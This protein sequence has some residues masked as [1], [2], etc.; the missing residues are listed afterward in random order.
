MK[1]LIAII[2][3]IGIFNSS[4]YLCSEAVNLIEAE[5]T[6]LGYSL[7]E[8][9]KN[10]PWLKRKEDLARVGIYPP[11]TISKFQNYLL[12]HRKGFPTIGDGLDAKKN[13]FYSSKEWTDF[14]FA[15]DSRGPSILLRSKRYE[16]VM[17]YSAQVLRKLLSHAK[18]KHTGFLYYT[19]EGLSFEELFDLEIPPSLADVKESLIKSRNDKKIYRNKLIQSI[20]ADLLIKETRDFQE[21]FHLLE[22][23]NLSCLDSKV[24]QRI[25]ELFPVYELTNTSNDSL[26]DAFERMTKFFKQVSKLTE[27]LVERVDSSSNEELLSIFRILISLKEKVDRSILWF[28]QIAR[29]TEDSIRGILEEME[30]LHRELQHCAEEA[31][32]QWRVL[33]SIEEK[34]KNVVSREPLPLITSKYSSNILKEYPDFWRVKLSSPPDKLSKASD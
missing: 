29:K 22:C 20:V 15:I 7:E 9:N 17:E 16:R 26:S 19:S 5:T 27:V 1:K 10:F 24:L 14:K 4:S 28:E 23:V 6:Q 12:F 18:S 33:K 2:L 31:K 8:F 25:A 21:Y 30:H 3:T 32:L 13:G 34:A 11:F